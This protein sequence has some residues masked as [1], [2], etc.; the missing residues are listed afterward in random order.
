[1][2]RRSASFSSGVSTWKGRMAVSVWAVV[3]IT[4]SVVGRCGSGRPPLRFGDLGAR[5]PLPGGAQHQVSVERHDYRPSPQ[6]TVRLAGLVCLW[7]LPAWL[8]PCRM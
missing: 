7:Q 1:R 6:V 4:T 3:L 2:R 5:L 8:S